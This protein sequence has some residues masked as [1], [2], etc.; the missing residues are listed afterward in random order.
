MLK[1]LLVVFIGALLSQGS[2]APTSKA[3]NNEDW[4]FLLLAQF[5]P[6]TSCYYFRQSGCSVPEKVNNW[7]IHGLWPS[8]ANEPQPENCN[9][10]MPFDYTQIE[11]LRDRL[12]LEW[13]YYNKSGARTFLWEHEWNKHGTCAYNLPTL[14]GEM[15]YFTSAM[16]LYQT[17]N[18]FG[19]LKAHG[20]EPSEEKKFQV[21]DIFDILNEYFQAKP[22]II[23]LHNS[24]E[25]VYYIEEIWLCFNKDLTAR[26]CEEI[27]VHIETALK[28]TSETDTLFRKTKG[29]IKDCPQD[30]KVYYLPI[31]HP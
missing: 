26:D 15:N 10:S 3:Q 4:E 8:N 7:T 30:R 24:E 25:N 14:Q 16:N 6:T 28:F 11:S 2:T 18:L 27:P 20:I 29:Y 31:K 17:I 13:P 5:W 19:V 1:Q 22:N 21:Q 12:D 23:C 9:S